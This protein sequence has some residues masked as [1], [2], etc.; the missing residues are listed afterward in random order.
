MGSTTGLVKGFARPSC[1]ATHTAKREESRVGEGSRKEAQKTQLGLKK[2]RRKYERTYTKGLLSTQH[3][4]N[5]CSALGEN[6]WQS[7]GS[8]HCRAEGAD[9]SWRKEGRS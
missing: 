4:R 6:S 7:V 9:G 5:S 3:S 2:G 1:S 8:G